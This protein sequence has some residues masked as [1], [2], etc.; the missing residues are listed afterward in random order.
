MTV[1]VAARLARY[2]RGAY[3][4]VPSAM[5]ALTWAYGIGGLF[6]AVDPDGPGRRP[7]GGTA[8]A[9]ASVLVDLLLMRALDDVRDLEYDRRFHP[10]R[11]LPAGVVRTGDL[12]V[13]YRTG[14]VVLLLLNAAWPWRA[15]ILLCQLGYAAGA[16]G[17]H[18]RWGRPSADRLFTSLLVGLPAPVLLHLYLYAGYLDETGQRADRYGLVAVVVAVLAA[19]HPE[20]AGKIT[21]EPRAGERTYV[22]TLG[23]HGSVTL[24]LAVPVL[25]VCLLV[26]FSQAPAGWT[27]AAVLPL[28]LPALGAWRFRRG[29]PRWPRAEPPLYLLLSFAGYAVLGL[30][31]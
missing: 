31:R 13:L 26:R 18:R 29:G 14:A 1:R 25:S 16:A 20:L 7:G 8:V 12:A 27:S 24:A 30:T 17:V 15:G 11:P 19:G 28:V 9:A 23:V 10:G 5:V 22:S 2:V 4:P 6:A 3:P 21:R